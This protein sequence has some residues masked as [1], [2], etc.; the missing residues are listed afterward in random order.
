M[1]EI[2]QVTPATKDDV[3]TIKSVIRNNGRGS[4]RELGD[5]YLEQL[6]GSGDMWLGRADDG[7][8]GGQICYHPVEEAGHLNVREVGSVI[9]LP[10]FSGNGAVPYMFNHTAGSYP[11]QILCGVTLT[12]NT[13]MQNKFKEIGFRMANPIETIG[14][15][16]T[17]ESRTRDLTDR[18]VWVK[19]PA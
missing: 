14:I 13:T 18:I 2:V 9:V 3:Q 12:T 5:D 10:E 6:I 4:V 15:F 16:G 19:E 17:P 11:D 7:S 1:K 8:L